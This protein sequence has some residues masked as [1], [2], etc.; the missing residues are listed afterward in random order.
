MLLRNEYELGFAYRDAGKHNTDSACT[1]LLAIVQAHPG[2]A[3]NWAHT[4]NL[5][6]GMVKHII[7]VEGW[8][9][10]PALHGK[11]ETM[12]TTAVQV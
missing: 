8:E 9:P 3:M 1:L 6:Y 2:S 5:Q 7:H 11:D 12:T 4:K 10:Q